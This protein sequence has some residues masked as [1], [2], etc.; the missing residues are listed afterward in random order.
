MTI[1]REFDGPCVD[2]LSEFVLQCRL[3]D[4]SRLE[5]L[6]QFDW[7]ISPFVECPQNEIPKFGCYA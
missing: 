5:L 6:K 3:C 1:G 4:F 2:Q 7:A